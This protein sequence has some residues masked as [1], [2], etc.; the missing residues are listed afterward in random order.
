MSKFCRT[1]LGTTETSK[2]TETKQRQNR[3]KTREDRNKTE[4]KQNRNKTGQGLPG[5]YK[6]QGQLLLVLGTRIPSVVV[7]RL[8]K[9]GPP[10][11]AGP[12]AAG[13][14]SR[15]R[16]S[17]IDGRGRAAASL[18]RPRRSKQCLLAG[19]GRE[20]VAEVVAGGPRTRPPRTDVR[21]CSSTSSWWS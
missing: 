1:I 9:A 20:I 3:N 19:T 14:S 5:R 12:L 10:A 15:V 2:E 18:R 21:S 17:K 4:T 11:R 16:S 7:V 13:P 8:E 6:A